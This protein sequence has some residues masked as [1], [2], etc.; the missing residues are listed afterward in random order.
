MAALH[1]SPNNITTHKILYAPWSTTTTTTTTN[2]GT[3]SNI[4]F[5][6]KKPKNRPI[7]IRCS[8]V[9]SLENIEET[10]H[11]RHHVELVQQEDPRPLSQIW[12]EIHGERNW[13]GLLDPMNSHLRREIIRYG[14]MAQACYDS[15][16]FDPGSKYCGACKYQG[17]SF[18]ERLGMADRGYTLTRYLYAT[19][20]INLPNFFQKSKMSSIWSPHANW[21]GY[22]AVAT[23]EAEIRRLGR[24]DGRHE[25]TEKIPVSVISFA[26]PRVGNLKFKERCDELGVKVLRVINVHDKVPTVPGIIT[27][28]KFLYQKYIEE[29]MGFP[30]SY[31]HVGVELALDHAR[32]PYLKSTGDIRNS[33]NLEAHLH[34]V[35]GYHGPDKGF[36]QASG[37]DVALVNKSCDFLKAECGVPPNWWQDEHKGM[38]RGR[39]GRW[40]VPERER[41]EAH[42]PD[43]AHLFE[44]VVKRVYQLSCGSLGRFH[45][46]DKRDKEASVPDRPRIAWKSPRR[47]T[48]SSSSQQDDVPDKSV[49]AQGDVPRKR[50]DVASDREVGDAKRSKSTA[51]K[52]SQPGSDFMDESTRPRVAAN[53]NPRYDKGKHKIDDTDSAPVT[54]ADSDG[55]DDDW[56]P[57]L[58]TRSSSTIFVKAVSGLTDVQ[59]QAVREMGLGRLLDL[60]ITTTPLKMGFWL[61]NNFNP[62]DRKLRLHD[63]EKLHVMEEDVHAALGLP[64]GDIE[65]SNKKKRVASD[66]LD[67]WVALFSV[68]IPSNITA[69]KV[70][71]KIRECTEGDDTFKCHFIV[72]MVTCLFESSSNGMANFRVL[73][74]LED[75]MNVHNMNWCS[76]MIRCLVDTKRAWDAIGASPTR[77][78]KIGVAPVHDGAND[79]GEVHVSQLVDDTFWNDPETLSVIDSIEKAVKWRNTLNE[80]LKRMVRD[81]PSFSLGISSDDDEFNQNRTTCRASPTPNKNPQTTEKSP[82]VVTPT[83]NK[84]PQTSEKSPEVVTPTP[85]RNPQTAEKSLEVVT[86]LDGTGLPNQPTNGEDNELHTKGGVST[87]V[88]DVLARGDDVH[89]PQRPKRK[90]MAAS[91]IKSPFKERVIDM[92]KKLDVQE[93]MVSN[94]ISNNDALDDDGN[95]K[96]GAVTKPVIPLVK[97]LQRSVSKFIGDRRLVKNSKAIALAIPNI[98]DT[99]WT[100][101]FD[102]VDIGVM[103]MRHMKTFK[104]DAA[105]P[106]NTQLKKADKGQMKLFRKHYCYF[107]A[108]AKNNELAGISLTASKIYHPVYLAT[109]ASN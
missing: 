44:Q 89:R 103:T 33:H 1:S 60:T 64:H 43:T 102:E 2:K 48:G 81:G 21:M 88:D 5:P 65:I 55:D 47:R 87:E 104:G 91:V 100:E 74:M 37:R 108:C 58:I 109:K 83:P 12:R 69:S 15:F 38:V 67:Q 62:M 80:R 18:F 52:V 10:D 22:V 35:D 107:I 94:W 84:N 4:L 14:E 96:G 71:D 106:L 25:T 9:A 49:H 56:F 59:K 82:E 16:D 20:N 92:T 77:V 28:E 46:C 45:I 78:R 85:D 42:P 95:C 72:L 26:G 17:A 40:V 76:F 86:Q 75:L 11:H 50:A 90:I 68:R 13:E 70:F 57:S 8:A 32:S 31:A 63:G 101:G 7:V 6:G 66:V 73:H 41:I 3:S 98:I 79:T 39:D 24:H 36:V 51:C 53:K 19:S 29:K 105:K 30:W 27:N 54:G 97:L 23:D 93:K 61:V 99:P 34:L